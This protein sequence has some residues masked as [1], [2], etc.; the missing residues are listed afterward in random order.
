MGPARLRSVTAR[1]SNVLLW[2]ANALWAIPLVIVIRMLRGVVLIRLG[3]FDSRRIGHFVFDVACHL[4]EADAEKTLDLYWLE[5]CANEQWEVMVRR[6]FCV[7]GVTR[8][9]DLWNRKIPGGLH[10][11]IRNYYDGNHDVGAMIARGSC[12]MG[13][14][15]TEASQAKHWLLSKG[16]KEGEPWIC[17]LVRD[18]HFLENDRTANSGFPTS[19]NW[20]YHNYRNSNIQ[21][22]VPGLEWLTNQGVWVLRMGRQAREPLVSANPMIIDYAFDES[23]SDLLD[24]WLF[25]NCHGSISTAT[26]LDAV[27]TVYG[28]PNLFVNALPITDLLTYHRSVWVPKDLLWTET[29]RPLSLQEHFLHAYSH[30]NVYKMR[31]IGI[32]DL[33][34]GKIL[35]A[36]RDFWGLIQSQWTLDPSRMRWQEAFWR[37]FDDSGAATTRHQTRTPESL[38]GLSWLVSVPSEIFLEEDDHPPEPSP[39]H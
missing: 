7:L 30:S 38:V 20:D 1:L 3:T 25:A 10:H 6:T 4:Q 26:G 34:Q 11:Q 18:G 2:S 31:G 9:I 27:A 39:E 17:V 33:A 23:Q 16:W 19:H 12:P 21:D 28:I 32:Q 8:W 5:D 15:A 37:E 36:I 35:D 14:T 24:I 29:R 22:F 13:F